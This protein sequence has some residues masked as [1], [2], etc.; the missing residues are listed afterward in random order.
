[1]TFAGGLGDQGGVLLGY[2]L[3]LAKRQMDLGDAEGLLLGGSGDIAD[4]IAHPV[5]LLGGL[6]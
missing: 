4:V 5:A 2:L 3:Q 6:L 1:M